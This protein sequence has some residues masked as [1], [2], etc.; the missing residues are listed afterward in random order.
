MIDT[1]LKANNRSRAWL[2][3][4]VGITEASLS[5]IVNNRQTASLTVACEIERITGVPPS[6]MIAAPSTETAA[7]PPG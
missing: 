3:E 7:G 5:R 4:K 2:A 6:E 1:W